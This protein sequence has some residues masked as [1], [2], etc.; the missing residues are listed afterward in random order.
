MEKERE[1]EKHRQ[2]EEDKDRRIKSQRLRILIGA[3][4]GTSAIIL[5]LTAHII[6]V[7]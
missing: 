4:M 3:L 2:E 5:L 7:Y 1:T 6:M